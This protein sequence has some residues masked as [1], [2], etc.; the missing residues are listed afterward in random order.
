MADINQTISD[1]KMGLEK[2]LSVEASNVNMTF[3]QNMFSAYH[4]RETNTFKKANF[5]PSTPITLT[6]DLYAGVKEPTKTTLGMLC[7]NR[8]VLE[9]PGVIEASGYWNNEI[10][11]DGL[12]DFN[13]HV[14][15]LFKKDKITAEQFGQVIDH[16]DHIGFWCSSFLGVSISS[17]LILPNKEVEKRKAE[18]FKLKHDQLNSSDPVQQILASNEIEKELIGM[19]EKSMQ[20]DYGYDIYSSGAGNFKNNYKTVNIMRGAVYN[21]VTHKYDVVQAS[22]MNGITKKDIPAFGNSVL[23][24]AYPSA[25]GTQEAGYM[26]KI[27]LSLMQSEHIDPNPASDCGTT[28][29]IPLDVTKKNKKYVIDRYINDNGKKVLLTEENIN[30]YVDKTI[31]LYSPQCCKNEAICGKC[32]GTVFHNLGVTNIGLLV[33]QITQR[34]LNYK[35]KSKHDLSTSAFVLKPEMVFATQNQY[36]TMQDNH[37]VNKVTMRMYIPRVLE[38]IKGFIK[39]AT[40]LNCFGV[41]P[42][43]FLD[44]SGKVILSTMMTVPAMVNYNIYSDIEET[45]EHY[46]VE[47]EPGSVVCSMGIQQSFTNVEFFVNQIYL[48]ST[49][50]QLPYDIMTNM[51]FKCQTINATDLTGSSIIYETMARRVCRSGN[52]TFAKVYG[53]NKNVDPMSYTKPSFRTAVQEAGALQGLLFQDTSG[54]I[55]TALAKTLDGIEPD[56]TPLE[57]IIRA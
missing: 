39:E 33:S 5:D 20:G 37:L 35:L 44:N 56:A 31:H 51:F 29:T 15:T 21:D 48:W 34:L 10:D 24:G 52:D 26:S 45:S 3:L 50:P 18:L 32:A 11:K 6:P 17:N 36:C 23:A 16:R 54:S 38:E 47:Y 57:T 8:Y 12:D 25:V 9:A 27:I 41:F 1:A 43:E 42:V 30:N 40:T 4:D 46:I 13:R 22:L 14:S 2:I 7:F 49:S 53:A 28:V 19:M 55:K